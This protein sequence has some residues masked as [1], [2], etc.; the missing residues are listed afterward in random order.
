M[1]KLGNIL[2][3]M[4]VCAFTG[5][6]FGIVFV[7]MDDLPFF[8]SKWKAVTLGAVVAKSSY[9]L[10]LQPGSQTD[11]RFKQYEGAVFERMTFPKWV[12]ATGTLDI[13][14]TRHASG[15]ITDRSYIMGTI[16]VSEHAPISQQ[17]VNPTNAES[18]VIFHFSNPSHTV[19][20]HVWTSPRSFSDRWLFPSLRTGLRGAIV[21][22]VIG[23]L[24]GLLIFF[25]DTK[26]RD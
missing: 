16:K 25:F 4:I 1:D 14:T 6:I 21:G 19:K 15:S 8:P 9:D 11:F 17:E 12:E 18:A 22:L 2:S 13:V 24:L 23:G 7:F 10:Y 20:L 3:C 5:L 26:E